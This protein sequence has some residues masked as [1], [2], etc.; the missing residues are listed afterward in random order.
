MSS[1][2]ELLR[3]LERDDGRGTD[4]R[5]TDGHGTGRGAS[6][7]ETEERT[8][9]RRAT[10]NGFRSRLPS[11][12]RLFSPKGFLLALVLTLGGFFLGGL[13]PVVGGVTGI[14]GVFLA[15]FLLGVAG[16]KR[17]LELALAGAAT[18]GVGLLLD[19]LVL[20]FLGDVALPL[21]GIGAAAGLLAAVVGHY[22]GR[23]LYDGLTREL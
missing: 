13:V 7:G 2:D 1:T 22:V 3:E 11:P 8:T 17:Y 21:A 15:G 16:R 4:K 18:G 6:T 5:E 20:S 23:D 19:R 14:V 12:S 9:G 10:G